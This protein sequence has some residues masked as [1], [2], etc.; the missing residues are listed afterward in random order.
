MKMRTLFFAVVLSLMLCLPATAKVEDFGEFLVDVPNGW[1]GIKVDGTVYL[2]T[3]PS[4]SEKIIFYVIDNDG[5]NIAE[6]AKELANDYKENHE[7]NNVSEPQ[8][9][10]GSYV[11]TYKYS[12][13]EEHDNII[14]IFSH[15]KHIFTIEIV[16]KHADMQ[17]ILDSVKSK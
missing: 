12:E 3:T 10:N 5:R 4:E 7:F 9:E 13:Y 8:L 11:F 17:K 6:Y 2:S 14:R 16:G 1:Q 15:D